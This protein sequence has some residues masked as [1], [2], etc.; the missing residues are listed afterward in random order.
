MSGRLDGLLQL[1]TTEAD[2]HSIM[3]YWLPAEIMSD[4]VAVEGGT[5]IDEQDAQFAATVCRRG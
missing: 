3:C 4:G 1:Q 5:D 2:I